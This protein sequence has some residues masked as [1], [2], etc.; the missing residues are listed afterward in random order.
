M[1]GQGRGLLTYW[2]AALQPAVV[3]PNWIVHVLCNGWGLSP[4]IVDDVDCSTL[5]Y[6]LEWGSKVHRN[7]QYVAYQ[8]LLTT[9]HPIA[10]AFDINVGRDAE[11]PAGS[12][13]KTTPQL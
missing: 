8:V 2:M 5:I 12:F 6:T 10:S 1:S 9:L 3:L 13:S 11:G 4:R 7:L